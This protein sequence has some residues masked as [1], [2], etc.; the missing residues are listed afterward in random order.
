M[1]TFSPEILKKAL[2]I[3]RKI[4]KSGD[5][6]S[7][8]SEAQDQFEALNVNLIGGLPD[9]LAV[10]NV[11]LT[12]VVPEKLNNG[13]KGLAGVIDAFA[14]ADES[15]KIIQ[16]LKYSTTLMQNLQ[17]IIPEVQI[18]IAEI[19]S[20][21]PG[22]AKKLEP[23]LN[24]A[25][26]TIASAITG[27]AVKEALTSM[28]VSAATPAAIASTLKKMGVEN[29]LDIIP[30]EIN[31]VLQEAVGKIDITL[32]LK[33]PGN[34][35]EL[36]ELPNIDL[37]LSAVGD[38]LDKFTAGITGAI[39][40]IL[41]SI[42]DLPI[43]DAL[44]EMNGSIAQVIDKIG[45]PP[46]LKILG[47][48]NV[49]A[50]EVSQ[51]VLQLLSNNKLQEAT[52]L[53]LKIPEF[54]SDAV[55]ITAKITLL[56]S[57][58][59]SVG[60]LLKRPLAGILGKQLNEVKTISDLFQ[61]FS[62]VNAYEE[63]LSELL[64]IER[65]ITKVVFHWSETYANEII[66]ADS[67]KATTGE[68]PYHY[69]IRKNG[70]IQRGAGLNEI[71]SHVSTEHDK[72]SISVLVVGGRKGQT[73]ENSALSS[74]SISGI[75]K[76]A[77]TKLMGK[78]YSAYPGIQMFGHGDLDEN[79]SAM[80]PGVNI[81][82]VA[83]T[84]FNKT[85][86]K[87]PT[88][89]KSHLGNQGALQSAVG[90]TYSYQGKI[91]G[92]AP[93]RELVDILAAT[94]QITGFRFDIFSAGQMPLGQFM[95]YPASRRKII[96]KKYYLDKNPHPVRQGSV[97]HD[98]GWAVDCIVYDANNKQIN[99]ART[100]PEAKYVVRTLLQQGI[101]AVGAGPNYM[102]GNIHIDIAY[103]KNGAGAVKH[104]GQGGRVKNT[105]EW[106]KDIFKG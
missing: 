5:F 21:V 66:T 60:V 6:Q 33:L 67:L 25:Q 61:G 84:K 1:S 45:F 23:V 52:G 54:K 74:D 35:I 101:T 14:P 12:A 17:D 55:N 81:Q 91:R 102:T 65:P 44:H 10:L 77:I 11:N 98:G 94:A 90:V 93:R 88:A 26:K 99:F 28:A 92:M 29:G 86:E 72:D 40:D 16:G 34:L 13:I 20:A 85:N 73:G 19:T 103:G 95:N 9:Q 68:V 71:V 75:Q 87:T 53:L 30:S 22:L 4:I 8:L 39:G 50:I 47:K 57:S 70:S 48:K 49:K 46:V 18:P 62:I 106:L 58:L 3:K 78:L 100:S 76:D 79:F 80:E 42:T 64:F 69:I 83:K 2:D 43:L 59:G 105:P 41:P 7:K 31:N 56:N 38:K 82:A 89:I 96:G 104:W 24:D 32:K 63:V 37:N 51:N 36:L 97:R 27:G 15:G